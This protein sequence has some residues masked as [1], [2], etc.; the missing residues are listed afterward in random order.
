MGRSVIFDEG[1][2]LLVPAGGEVFV[3]FSLSV[4]FLELADGED[5]FGGFLPD[6]DFLLEDL[7]LFFGAVLV[8]LFN[9]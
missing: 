1:W 5:V 3:G 8:V 4:F 6:V 7:L 2:Y 9:G